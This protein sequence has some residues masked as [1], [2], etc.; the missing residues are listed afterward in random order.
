MKMIIFLGGDEML[1]EDLFKYIWNY[2]FRI[3]L[4]GIGFPVHPFR[5]ILLVCFVV[6]CI[7][8]Y[9]DYKK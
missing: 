5:L 1:L 6:L 8:I 4:F 2:G 3:W 7:V 9:K